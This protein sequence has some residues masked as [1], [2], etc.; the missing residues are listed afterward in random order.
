MSFAL[1]YYQDDCVASV[2]TAW[3]T[4]DSVMVELATGLGKTEIFTAI[5][6]AWENGRV[7]VICPAI[8]LIGQ[9]AK[10]ICLRT[11]IMPDIEQAQNWSNESE[12][13][14]NS[15]IVGC[16]QSLCRHKEA[17]G[18]KRFERLKDIGLVIVDECHLSIT[19]EYEAL[20]THFR[21]QGAKVLGVTAT[22]KRHDKRAM[23]NLYQNCAYQFGIADAVDDGWLVSAITDC[24]QLKTLDLTGVGIKQTVNGKDFDQKALNEKL[25]NQETIY[26][27]AE[28]TARESSGLK[29]V[30]YCSSVD[31]A[32]LVAERLVDNYGLKADWICSDKKRCT[33]QRRAEVL[34]SFTGD[35]EGTQIVC[36]VGILTTGWDFP[37]LQH[38]VMARPTR[39]LSLYTQ[40]FGR[41]TR[42]LPDVV[43]F[44]A[45]TAELRKAAIAMSEKPHFKVTDLVDSSMEHK[46]ITSLD[47]LGGRYGIEVL[48]RAKAEL[49]KS[50]LGAVKI[51]E[52][53][54]DAKRRIEEE[55]EAAERARRAQIQA[56]AEYAKV[57]VDPFDV[58]TRGSGT[59]KK[60][61]G[62]KMLFGKHKGELASSVPADYIRWKLD[63]MKNLQPWYRGA[64]TAE[65]SR[66]S[67][68]STQFTRPA[69]SLD[70]VNNALWEASCQG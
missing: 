48:D 37:A 1:R 62:L 33:D 11:G 3:E 16:K 39:S 10:K 4:F 44:E 26:E 40:I 43:D 35:D 60:K 56:R 14:R 54:L 59:A 8:E 17:I 50:T 42:P 13:G 2:R 64:L 31:E 29:T 61:S 12:W 51:D 65:L 21:S 58:N 63:N 30:V 41:G 34:D 52:A 46:I 45:S 36:N 28:V 47:V 20:L 68:T 57:R 38:I 7:L 53:L 70:S 55:K 9:A 49:A 32:K 18:G 6:S 67:S 24:I 5:A 69:S 25:E 66:R 27:I 15:F 19:E 23:G 22:A